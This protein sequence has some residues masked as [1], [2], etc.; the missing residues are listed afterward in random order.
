MVTVTENTPKF[1]HVVLQTNR[2]EKMRD[3]Y[4]TVLG[5]RVV[6][7]NPGMCFITFDEEHHRIAFVRPPG[8]PLV[9]R[10]PQTVGLQHSAYTFPHLQS[11]L[12]KYSSLR[13]QGVEP[14][15][16]VQHGVT[17]SLY[18][19][20]PDGNL[21]ELQVDN[22]E[23]PLDATAYMEGPEYAADPIGPSFDPQRMLDALAQGAAPGELTTRSWAL[24]GPRLPHP[25]THLDSSTQG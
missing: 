5:A 4:C 18:Y 13:S 19:R 17:T 2:L 25:M 15:V 10:T 11:L 23:E 20:D 1:A 14:L 22:F 24:T 6:Y 12:D 7:E 16:P 21:A 9:E 3:W 8:P